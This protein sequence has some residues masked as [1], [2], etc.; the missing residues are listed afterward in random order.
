MSFDNDE[1]PRADEHEAPSRTR[2]RARSALFAAT[3]LA[4]VAVLFLLERGED[5]AFLRAAAINLAVVTWSSF[6]LPLRGLPPFESYYRLRRW[7]RSGRLHHLLGVSAFRALVRRGPLARFNRALP[8]AWHSGD[9]VRIEREIRAAE[10]GHAIAFAIVLVIALV[11]L[12]R[13]DGARAAWLVA[14]DVPMNLYP[15]LLQ[16]DHRARLAR[17]RSAE[18]ERAQC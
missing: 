7:E 8:A 5:A 17:E 12:V 16:R 15:T 2:T 1:R 18:R 4:L 13:G 11:A 3:S 14:L 6:V 9:L 10:A